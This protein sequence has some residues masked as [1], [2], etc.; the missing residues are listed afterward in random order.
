M[1]D[2]LMMTRLLTQMVAW[3]GFTMNMMSG[4]GKILIKPKVHGNLV[5]SLVDT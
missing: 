3:V 5:V 2:Q 1:Y 4:Q